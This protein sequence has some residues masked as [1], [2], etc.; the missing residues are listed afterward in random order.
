MPMARLRAMIWESIFTH[1]MGRY[2]RGVYKS[3]GDITTLITGP[4]RTGKELVA[5]AISLSRYQ[6]F[7][8][9]AKKFDDAHELQMLAVN[10]SALSSI[11]IGDHADALK[12]LP[13]P[14]ATENALHWHCISGGAESP[15]VTLNATTEKPTKEKT[16]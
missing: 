4:S 6:P 5:S 2:I 16:P 9:V 15:K 10:F 8:P 3:I 11:G 12:K 14:T 1:D 13:S 7:D